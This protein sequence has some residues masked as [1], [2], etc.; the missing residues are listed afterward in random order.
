[1]S[2]NVG[3]VAR[4]MKNCCLTDLRVVAPKC[5]I[6]NDKARASSSGSEDILLNAK[7][8]K[9]LEEAT[10]DLNTVFATTARDRSMEKPLYLPHEAMEKLTEN[11]G[12]IFGCERTG[13]TNDDLMLADAIINIPLNPNHS[14]L[15]LAQAVLIVSYEHFKLGVKPHD[16]SKELATKSELAHFFKN[17]E[18]K[19][20]TKEYFKI[21]EKRP[22]MLRNLQNIF[23]RS[24][25]TSQEIRTLHGVINH[26]SKD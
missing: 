3:A 1:M 23:N 24:M 4:A 6:T 16:N 17:L 5:E 13:L 11:S 21:E 19:L 12:V 10:S 25:L 14:S 22:R 8:F 9:T 26:L 7:I 18:E 2:E 15:N 20:D